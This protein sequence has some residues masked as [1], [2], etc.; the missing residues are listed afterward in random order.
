MLAP[1]F[2][3][4]V[5]IS[6]ASVG[7]WNPGGIKIIQFD[8][9][10][11]RERPSPPVG[12]AAVQILFVPVFGVPAQLP[13]LPTTLTSHWVKPAVALSAKI[14]SPVEPA[15]TAPNGAYALPCN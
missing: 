1:L 2:V 7:N 4:V 11:G 5:T 6:D 8:H 15:R 9:P 3:S 10:H 12:E 13:V 14:K